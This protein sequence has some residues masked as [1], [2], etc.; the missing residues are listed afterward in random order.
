MYCISYNDFLNKYPYIKQQDPNFNNRIDITTITITGTLEYDNGPIPDINNLFQLT[1]RLSHDFIH[2]IIFNN[3]LFTVKK[4]KMKYVKKC[5]KKIR[6]IQ[7]K[8]ITFKVDINDTI[9][10]LKIFSSGI[11]HITGA[12]NISSVFWLFYCLFDWFKEIGYC[13][14]SFK[15]IKTFNVELINCKCYFPCIID[16][17]I[18]Y[19]DMNKDFKN[20]NVLKIQYDPIRHSAIKIKIKKE[21]AI[22]DADF[23]TI[24]VFAFGK[25]LITG[26]SNYNEVVYAYK[27]FYNYL[28]THR[29]CILKY[30]ESIINKCIRDDY[31]A[32]GK[33]VF[34]DNIDK[35]LLKDNTAIDYSKVN[36]IKFKQLLIPCDTKTS[37]D[38]I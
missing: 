15:S 16:K 23:I 36:R 37:N 27:I 20:D 11:F 31:K 17:Y 34:N 4:Q 9:L 33:I 14:M 25:M 24:L 1:T 13:D 19:D 3:Q 21:K 32:T 6:S 5:S 22:N 28:A 30:D 2:T 8:Q 38:V 10:S 18:L 7:T 12:N 26:A 29:K 35:F